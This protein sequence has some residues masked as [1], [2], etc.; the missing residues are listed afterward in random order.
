MNHRKDPHFEKFIARTRRN[1]CYISKGGGGGQAA[2]PQVG[3]AAMRN[4]ATSERMAQVAEEEL[5][6]NREQWTKQE[7]V[8]NEIQS[9]QLEGM[10][11]A[12]ERG[13]QQWEQYKQIFAPIEERMASD[14]MTF[15]SEERKA[16]Q[17]GKAAADVSAAHD[18]A[19]AVNDRNMQRMGVDPGDPRYAGI[20]SAEGLR[21]AADTAG[22]MTKARDDTELMGMSMR[23]GVANFGRGMTN[24]SMAQDAA[25]LQSAGGAAGTAAGSTAA[26]NAGVNSAQ[27]WYNGSVNA[28]QS[29]MS[30]L[31]QQYAT[32]SAN[33][34]AA[35][36]R[37]AAESAGVGKLVGTAAMM[38]MKD[39]GVVDGEKAT[40]G[41][42][43]IAIRDDSGDI[44]PTDGEALYEEPGLQM[45]DGGVARRN[46]YSDGAMVEGPGTS[47]SDSIPAQLSDGEAVLNAEA[48]AMV[49]EDFIN[50]MNELGLQRREAPMENPPAIEGESRRIA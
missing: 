32:Q 25:S 16:S 47:T 22:A 9:A 17:A 23:Q 38:F 30:G 39:G 6:W 21:R 36:N 13:T 45:A 12:N 7:P 31:N 46:N 28:N 27:S 5:L 34:N 35:A 43:L 49:G 48:T 18:A 42:R 2:D 41:L 10:K 37:G 8:Y 14:A 11:T 24:T 15:D 33:A 26:R 29:V 40:P 50:R 3:A 19:G 20:K 44:D 4:A 1:I